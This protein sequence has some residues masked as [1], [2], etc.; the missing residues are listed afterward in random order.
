MTDKNN[1]KVKKEILKDF[2]EKNKENLHELTKSQRDAVLDE[3][4]RVKTRKPDFTGKN[5]AEELAEEG[6]G[7]RNVPSKINVADGNNVTSSVEVEIRDE[8]LRKRKRNLNVI[9]YVMRECFIYFLIVKLFM[10]SYYDKHYLISL[11]IIFI[12]LIKL[13]FH[14]RNVKF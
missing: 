8:K 10:L 1:K 14:K 13:K 5:V 6:W 9:T 3:L 2:A 12:L 4:S 7:T 11:I